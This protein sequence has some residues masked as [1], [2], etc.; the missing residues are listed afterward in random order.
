[1][2]EQEALKFAG[3]EAARMNWPWD[4]RHVD[5]R[6]WRIWP[7]SRVWFLTSQVQAEGATV[8]LRINDRR[9]RVVWSRAL[10]TPA[11]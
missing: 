9:R 5:V 2:T 7:L 1:M 6:T 10:Y 4:H 3:A 11:A 8:K